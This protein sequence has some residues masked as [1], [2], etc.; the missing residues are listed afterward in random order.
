MERGL[1]ASDRNSSWT[2]QKGLSVLAICPGN[3]RWVCPGCRPEFCLRVG[4]KL[5][6]TTVGELDRLGVR[7]REAAF[8]GGFDPGQANRLLPE[9]AVFVAGRQQPASRRPKKRLAGYRVGAEGRISHLKRGYG[10]RRSRLRGHDG[11][12]AWVG[13]GILAYNLETLAARAVPAA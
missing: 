3:S 5:L 13:R 2:G 12:R 1:E 4:R 9:T 8:D 7:L 11:A 10:L 6:P